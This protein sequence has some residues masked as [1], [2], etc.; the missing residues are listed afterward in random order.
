MKPQRVKEQIARI[1]EQMRV[2]EI[3][4]KTHERYRDTENHGERVA[5]Q[6]TIIMEAEKAIAVIRHEYERA[7]REISKIKLNMR[8][9]EKRLIVLEN[10]EKIEK[11][12][13][14]AKELETVRKETD[15]GEERDNT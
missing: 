5:K 4:I 9:E 3:L 15:D 10:W 11:L 7:L 14:M 6:K 8:W 1:K 12:K 13:K 2:E